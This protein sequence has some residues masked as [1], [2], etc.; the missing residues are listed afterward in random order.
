MVFVS[1]VCL[2]HSAHFSSHWLV[3]RVTGY[4]LSEVGASSFADALWRLVLPLCLCLQC[5]AQLGAGLSIVGRLVWQA[6]VSGKMKR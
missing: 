1:S 6:E 4:R 2:N 5:S 3:G